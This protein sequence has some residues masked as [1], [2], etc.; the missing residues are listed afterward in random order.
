MA[1]KPTN[2]FFHTTSIGL[3]MAPFSGLL[4]FSFGGGVGADLEYSLTQK[5]DPHD[6]HRAYKYHFGFLVVRWGSLIALNSCFC[7]DFDYLHQ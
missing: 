5:R 2:T 1:A 4:P 3:E 7:S 6:H